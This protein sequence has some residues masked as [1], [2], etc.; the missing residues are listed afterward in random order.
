MPL[1]AK[2]QKGPNMFHFIVGQGLKTAVCSDALW[3]EL[4]LS[5]IEVSA[6][7]AI[8]R[9]GKGLMKLLKE[10]RGWDFQLFELALL[11]RVII[12]LK[13]QLT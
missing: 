9:L 2:M 13:A 11:Y 10:S 4:C 12:Q 1:N 7:C 6:Q 5:R 8:E 3:N